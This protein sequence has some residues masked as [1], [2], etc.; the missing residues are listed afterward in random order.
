MA[1]KGKDS[2]LLDSQVEEFRKI[3]TWLAWRQRQ[4]MGRLLRVPGLTMPR[5]LVLAFIHSRG[6][7]CTMGE[8]AEATD[9]CSATMTGIVDRLVNTGW[10]ERQ[11]DP[12][13]R[14]SVL[15]NLTDA[16]RVLVEQATDQLT[17]RAKR[18]LSQFTQEERADILRLLR[19][20]VEILESENG[21]S[22]I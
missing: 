3:T 9:Q 1:E 21:D 17:A 10:V 19:R 15:V 4:H 13:D 16:G 22:Y 18:T 5:F 8:L 7:R 20:Y 2:D 6:D 12:E 11:R 14:R